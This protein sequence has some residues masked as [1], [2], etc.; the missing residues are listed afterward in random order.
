M[1]NGYA[2]R[3]N[4]ERTSEIF[5]FELRPVEENPALDSTLANF[6]RRIEQTRL[7]RE[8]RLDAE[9]LVSEARCHAPP[10]SAIEESNLNQ[11]RF[12]DLFNRIFLFMDRSGDRSQADRT[13]VKLLNYR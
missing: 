11:V 6:S 12:D 2:P 1:A 4:D 3:T 9:M 10:G 8:R 7:V 5:S 13:A